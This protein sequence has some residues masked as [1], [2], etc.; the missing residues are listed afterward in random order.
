MQNSLRRE[1]PKAQ[2]T[3]QSDQLCPQHPRFCRGRSRR[4]LPLIGIGSKVAE[5]YQHYQATKIKQQVT[6]Y[7]DLLELYY[8]FCENTPI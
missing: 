6:D 2:G 5:F 8:N 3:H 1:Q 7:D 4:S